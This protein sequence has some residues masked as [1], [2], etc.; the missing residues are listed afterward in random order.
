MKRA[1]FIIAAMACAIAA[2]AKP[3][4]NKKAAQVA[5]R[6]FEHVLGVKG[7]ISLTDCS[8]QWQYS[9]LLLFTRTQGGFVIM[10][11]EDVARP[12]LAYSTTHTIKPA[13]LP[14][15]LLPI[16]K[17]YDDE[18]AAAKLELATCDPQWSDL[19]MYGAYNNNT[20]DNEP[21]SLGPLVQTQWFQS[22]PYNNYC[23]SGCPT[24]CV[25]TAAAQLMRYWIFPAFGKG[26]H[27]YTSD[28]GYG[29]LSADFSHTLYDWQNMPHQVT[30][31]SPAAQQDAVATLM[32]HIGVSVQMEYNPM[33]SGAVAGEAS[34]DTGAYCSQNALWRYFRYNRQDIIYHEKGNMSNNDW[35]NLIIAELQQMRPIL[36]NGRGPAGGHAF[37]CDGYD[38]QHYLHFNLGENGD[39]DGF[40]AVGAINYGIYS[41]NAEN[42]CVMGI[43]PDYGIYLNETNISFDRNGGSQQVWLATCDTSATPWAATCSDTWLHLSDTDFQYLGQVNITCDVNNS[44][45]DRTGTITFSQLGLTATLTVTQN[46]FDESE[47][48]P[49]TVVMECTRTGSAWANDAHLSFESPSGIIY[50]TAAHTTTATTSTATVNVA[51]GV[52]LIKYHRGGPQDRYYNYCVINPVGDTLVAVKNAYY[53]GNDVT[54]SNPCHTL[55]IDDTSNGLLTKISV[56]PN[57]T[58]AIVTINYGDLSATKLILQDH[59]G[60]TLHTFPA[61]PTIN[62]T[63]YPPAIYYLTIV[64]PTDAIV[65]KIVRH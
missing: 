45:N 24:G 58:E 63:T 39:G 38:S 28:A 37:I 23:P 20:K 46:A 64:T 18:I 61:T 30:L 36:Y 22:S 43:H 32:Y 25:A 15:A 53:N 29:V 31:S 50:G 8:D 56:Y 33:Q 65:R 51:P 59:I 19:L 2:F 42:N 26:S 54:I 10:A 12:I 60:R 48:C 49:L 9:H 62:L 1:L 21:D 44:G 27:S 40:Y 55:D 41:F 16:L 13:N 4:D 52:L 34:G 57:P 6:F 5:T 14:V 3:V 11:N 17:Q 7:G 35:I 47:Y